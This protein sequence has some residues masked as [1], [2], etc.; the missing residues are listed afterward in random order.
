MRAPITR[1]LATRRPSR[2]SSPSPRHSIAPCGLAVAG[3]LSDEGIAL[4][5]QVNESV[6][7]AAMYFAPDTNLFRNPL[8]GRGQEV[9]GE[10]PTLAAEFVAVY[11]RALQ[12]GP[13]MKY[14]K[15]VSRA[16]TPQP[17]TWR[18]CDPP[19]SPSRDSTSTRKSARAT[20]SRTIG[21]RFDPVFSARES[22]A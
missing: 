3:V 15:M 10:D 2:T 13:D 22:V 17:M 1:L 12:F 14:K 5:N 6:S 16:S 4:R 21:L 20:L 19:A 8:W 7:H 9:P 18:T 11:G